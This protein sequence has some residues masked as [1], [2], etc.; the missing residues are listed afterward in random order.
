[1]SQYDYYHLY[2][3]PEAAITNYHKLV[4]LKQYKY[5]LLQFWRPEV[6]NQGANRAKDS[7]GDS[8]LSL[9]SFWW[10]LAFFGLGLHHS[11]I[12]LCLHMA[13][14]PV[15]VEF[16]SPFSNEDNSN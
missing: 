13:F 7:G 1:M 16:P 9:S 8:F 14:S 15:S 11:N 5:I 2:Q 12:C 4:H 3:F 10:P 6:Q